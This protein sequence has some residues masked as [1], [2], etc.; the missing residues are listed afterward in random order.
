MAGPRN[1]AWQCCR[2][3]AD[4]RMNTRFDFSISQY[5]ALRWPGERQGE[6]AANGHLHQK[7][8]SH[9]WLEWPHLLPV[10]EL[11]PSVKLQLLT[12]VLLQSKPQG[13][14]GRPS[15][16]SRYLALTPGCRPKARA[17][18]VAAVLS[19]AVCLGFDKEQR[20]SNPGLAWTIQAEGWWLQGPAGDL[21]L[22]G[23]WWVSEGA[24]YIM[25]LQE[26]DLL[27]ARSLNKFR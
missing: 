24:F 15:A 10:N 3:V 20:Q 12:F 9:S 8:P 17:I 1:T 23:G 18:A 11:L 14:Y 19:R 25:L 26:S 6:A 13:S 5:I 22:A 27:I 21:G 2:L 7:L 16:A 4:Y